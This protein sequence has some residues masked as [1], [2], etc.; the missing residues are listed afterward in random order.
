MQRVLKISVFLILAL[1]LC[2]AGAMA[3]PFT[4]KV[5]NDF[6]GVAQ[7]GM[8]NGTPTANDNNDAGPDI[9]DAINL[10]QG[11][12]FGRNKDVDFLF[13]D[14]D[15]VWKELNGEII[16]I[17]LSAGYSNTVG[18]YTDLGTGAVKD[19]LLGPF[20]GFEFAG[21]GTE[22][23][24]FPAATFTLGTY[25]EFGWYLNSVNLDDVSTDYFSEPNLNPGGWDHMMTFD[26]PG[27]NGKEIY[28][29]TA[30]GGRWV[31]LNDPYLIAWE[32]L[33]FKD[34][35]LGDEDYD[36]MVL[37]VDKVAPV[38]VPEPTTLLLLGTG[39]VGLARISG[40]RFYRQ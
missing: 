23:D 5:A 29:N 17:G 9:N 24:P 8:V 15:E 33:P 16:L 13:V 36:D 14:S 28:V 39:L 34:N 27:A 10:L 7:G 25:T 26:L 18:V 6:Y 38:N 19:P 4:D 1:L 37:L 32:D 11:T 2:A 3:M 35:K 40:K 30:D 20:S 12:S 21:D 22:T 31:L